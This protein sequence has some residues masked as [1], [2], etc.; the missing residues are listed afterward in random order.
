[1]D[2]VR[3]VIV[4]FG[5]AGSVRH[6][7]AWARDPRAVVVGVVD[8][9]PARARHARALDLPVLPDLDAAAA[10]PADLWSVCTPPDAHV[11]AVHAALDAGRHV[12]VEK[13]MAPT[14]EACDAMTAHAARAGRLLA[15]G[16][17][18]RFAPAWQQLA[19]WRAD[20]RL[21]EI[22]T[23]HAVQWSSPGRAVP[24]WTATLP[25]GLLADEAPHHAYL[26]RDLLGPVDL[27]SRWRRGDRLEAVLTRGSASATLSVWMDAPRTEWWL[28]V[29]GTRGV[30]LV[31]L[32]R[33]I[34][35]FVP[36][37]PARTHRTIVEAPL[38]AGVAGAVGLAR[39]A[40]RRA[41]RGR[42]LY[43]TGALASAVLDALATGGPSP[44]PGAEGRDAVDLVQRLLAP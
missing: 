7:L 34:A 2:P 23:V 18:F 14:P 42:H 29:G 11:P 5:F 1:M 17:N 24:A 22:R 25:G 41:L 10:H 4:G 26:I 40:A 20:G 33:D 12:L 31:D 30:A 3:V 15:V 27:V 28:A 39:L 8:P 9:D 36:G 19:R 38:R 6:R 16:H 44:V 13:P 35:T 21:G 32:F 43:G 37:E